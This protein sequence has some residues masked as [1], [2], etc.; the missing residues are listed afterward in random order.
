MGNFA[1]IKSYIEKE[2]TVLAQISEENISEI[3][4]VME[5]AR[6]N[7]RR[8]YVC[9]NGG[10][11]VT[12]SHICCDFNKG[13]SHL[14]GPKYD[15]CCLSDNTATMMAIANDVDYEHIFVEQIKNRLV[16]K[17]VLIGISGSGNSK[18]ILLA[19]KYAN[20]IGAITVGFEGYDGGILKKEAQYS[21]H[22]NVDNMQIAE[23][24]HLMVFHMI[25][26]VL[27]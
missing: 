11:A 7:N 3:I 2:R 21:L 16:A 10:S 25:M 6:L 22:I 27:Y 18:N 4:K 24:V 14:Q 8:I 23:D 9:G 20:E 15:V 17:D 26:S 19:I 1:K 13:L 12:A 5:E